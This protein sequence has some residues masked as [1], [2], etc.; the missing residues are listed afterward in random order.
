MTEIALVTSREYINL[1][2]SDQCL[3]APLRERGLTPVAVD[4]ADPAVDWRRFGAVV[5]RST[6]DYHT[7]PHDFTAWLTHMQAQDV[8]LY[9]PP[10]LVL[11]NM[12]KT[13]LR[14]LSARGIRTI[15]THWLAQGDS[16]DLAA[17]MADNGW[18]DVVFK[19]TV[20]ASAH[21]IQRVRQADTAQSQPLFDAQLAAGGVM[22]Q[23]VM[24]DIRHGEL[25]L[26]FFNHAY[27]YTVRKMP[28]ADTIFVNGAYSNVREVVTPPESVIAAAQHAL[29]SA[30]EI[31]GQR[32]LYARVDGLLVE[33]AF[34]LMELELIEPGLMLDVAT[35]S[36]AE[37]FS[38]AIAA[39]VR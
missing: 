15:P 12:E 35:T 9:N 18:S 37:S 1:S 7:R 32:A 36:G 16:A 5:L 33:G 22:V 4:W 21:G 30:A 29:E 19:P 27:S 39:L 24:Q 25:S 11:W 28:G 26:V 3:L 20:G 17:V 31:T 8:P 38:D 10:A 6:W 13:Y 34:V 14:E 23:P 2:R